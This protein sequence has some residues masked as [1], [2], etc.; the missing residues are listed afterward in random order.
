M[1]KTANQPGQAEDKKAAVDAERKLT[2][3]ILRMKRVMEITGLSRSTIYKK[4]SEGR[5]APKVQLSERS[6]GFYNAD[7][8]AWLENPMGYRAP[9]AT[10]G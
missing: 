8:F 4:L 6:I 10:N 2:L 1:K 9:E 7:V 3:E 5:F